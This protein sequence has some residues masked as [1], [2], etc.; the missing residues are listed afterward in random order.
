MQEGADRVCMGPHMT[1]QLP[2]HLHLTTLHL[3]A[4]LTQD[5]QAGLKSL[6]FAVQIRTEGH[7][8]DLIRSLVEQMPH[9][10]LA[11]LPP[12]AAQ[13]APPLSFIER[14][15]PDLPV[16]LLAEAKPA[17]LA[18][19]FQVLSPQTPLEQL[20]ACIVQQVAARPAGDQR[21]RRTRIMQ[22]INQ[23]LQA[24]ADL[25]LVLG[26]NHVPPEVVA[27]RRYLERLQDSLRGQPR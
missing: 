20:L 10:V 19:R 24:L 5:L 8:T 4:Q 1:R 11:Y 16:V 3:P 25:T 14:T 12:D 13:I 17:Q 21:A 23:S 2:Q 22:Q 9:A 6:G 15:F 26:V 27:S 18:D 7:T